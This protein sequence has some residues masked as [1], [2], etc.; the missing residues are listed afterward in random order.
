VTLMASINTFFSG[1]FNQI[2]L[3]FCNLWQTN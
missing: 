2:L 1:D 3:V